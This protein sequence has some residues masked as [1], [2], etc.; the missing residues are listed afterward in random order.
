M[1]IGLRGIFAEEAYGTF[2]IGR[3]LMVPKDFYTRKIIDSVVDKALRAVDASQGGSKAIY[4]GGNGVRQRFNLREGGMCLRF[5]RQVFEVGCGFSEQSWDYKSLRANWTLDKLRKDG[6]KLDLDLNDMN[7]VHDL[8]PGDIVG[9]KFGLNG[10]IMLYVGVVKGVPCVA[11]NTSASNRGN[12]KRAGTK[13]TKWS[14]IYDRDRNGKADITGIYRLLRKEDWGTFDADEPESTNDWKFSAEVVEDGEI[15]SQGYGTTFSDHVTRTGVPADAEGIV[16]CSIPRG[17]CKATDG[18]PF[19]PFR[20]PD[21][22]LIKVWHPGTRK[23][24]YAPII[25]EGPA[26]RAEAGT[27]VKGSAMIDLTPQCW[28]DLG[29][30]PNRNDFVHI[31]VMTGSHV[32]GKEWARAW[33]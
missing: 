24:I 5:V 22:T 27:G 4:Q 16:A 14:E 29:G 13:L 8:L 23:I 20:I 1:K 21:Y 18:S 33:R 7:P 11:E 19:T 30:V 32:R 3:W 9:K 10:H 28:L 15:L 6:H 12:P 17:L 26:W 2:R 25:D 31:R